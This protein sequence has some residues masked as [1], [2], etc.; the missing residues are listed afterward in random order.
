[1][2]GRLADAADLAKR[3]CRSGSCAGGRGRASSSSLL[4]RGPPAQFAHA[5][6]PRHFDPSLD[7]TG[8]ASRPSTS[9]TVCGARRPRSD[10][11][12]TSSCC[13]TPVRH[14]AEMT[15]R[16]HLGCTSAAPRLH[17]GCHLGRCIPQSSLSPTSSHEAA[18]PPPPPPPL[19]LQ[20]MTA[21]DARTCTMA[22]TPASETPLP[23]WP[24][25]TAVAS[26]SARTS[27]AA[28]TA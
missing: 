20:P 9:S 1:M 18:I 22:S 2:R 24:R 10:R 11:R 16:L 26:A 27:S 28:G 4:T 15:P 13:T 12:P 21:V 7:L 14:A 23:R 5:A 8:T 3:P 25:A 17:L 19:P 6:L